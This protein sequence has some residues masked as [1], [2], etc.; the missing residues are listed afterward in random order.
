MSETNGNTPT[1]MSMRGGACSPLSGGGSDT[2]D[3]GTPGAPALTHGDVWEAVNAANRDEEEKTYGED[4]VRVL[5]VVS[6]GAPRFD[7]SGVSHGDS[8]RVPPVGGRGSYGRNGAAGDRALQPA[9]DTGGITDGVSFGMPGGRVER[10][11]TTVVPAP[12][13]GALAGDADTHSGGRCDSRGAGTGANMC[14]RAGCGVDCCGGGDGSAV[15]N[16][17]SS[18]QHPT[19]RIPDVGV[20]LFDVPVVLE[21]RYVTTPPNGDEEILGFS[22]AGSA[23]GVDVS[24]GEEAGAPLLGE[25]RKYVSSS[26]T[27]G[28]ACVD[29][30]GGA[31]GVDGD[32]GHCR[33]SNVGKHGDCR[34]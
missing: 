28:D 26:N 22:S 6:P 7:S 14:G 30:T 13:I 3:W 20:S 34:G 8:V 1:S 33:V 27:S 15:I 21:R 31:P 24:V 25:S 17:D 4:S 12:T 9:G 19:R 10:D 5:R 11:A 32:D 23:T 2:S 16:A 29:A 18:P